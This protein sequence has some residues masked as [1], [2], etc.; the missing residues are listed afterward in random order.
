MKG[1]VYRMKITPDDFDLFKKV[2]KV[3]YNDLNELIN[4]YKEVDVKI[5]EE[6]VRFNDYKLD[7][8]L[9]DNQVIRFLLNLHFLVNKNGALFKDEER[10]QINEQDW[11]MEYFKFLQAIQKSQNKKPIKSAFGR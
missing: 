1:S 4:A 6:G 7:F 10:R 9:K 8:E 11:Y 3:V 5:T 2:L